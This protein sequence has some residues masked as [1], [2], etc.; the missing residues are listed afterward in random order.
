MGRNEK[1][2]QVII[3]QSTQRDLG[4]SGIVR[5][6]SK[7]ERKINLERKIKKNVNHTCGCHS[8]QSNEGVGKM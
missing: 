8:S 5:S 4:P 3:S 1:E 2:K 6:N 7:I